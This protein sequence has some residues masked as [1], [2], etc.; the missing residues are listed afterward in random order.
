M[1][2]LWFILSLQFLQ[3]YAHAIYIYYLN[4]NISNKVYHTTNNIT[5]RSWSFLW[6]HFI[7]AG[8]CLFLHKD[9]P[10]LPY[11]TH[12]RL[13]S[14]K[15]WGAY[16]LS[17]SIRLVSLEVTFL[18]AVLFCNAP[19]R[20]GSILDQG[21]VKGLPMR[22]MPKYLLLYCIYDLKF[23]CC[24]NVKLWF[25]KADVLWEM[26]YWIKQS[27]LLLERFSCLYLQLWKF[28]S[29]N[30][31]QTYSFVIWNM[32]IVMFTSQ[33]YYVFHAHVL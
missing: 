31:P 18:S 32:A 9:L 7:L 22:Y 27:M 33:K 1:S 28:I 13:L 3:V 14:I 8:F 17:L 11:N 29:K 24:N 2:T 10:P 19:S 25:W 20:L 15:C 6:F 30:A 21:F 23:S 26:V 5:I 4:N 16:L 12:P